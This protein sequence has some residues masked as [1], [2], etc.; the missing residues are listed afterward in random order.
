MFVLPVAPELP[1]QTALQPA[2]T[3]QAAT[4]APAETTF[5]CGRRATVEV[6]LARE[7]AGRSAF[8]PLDAFNQLEIAIIPAPKLDRVTIQP[9]RV[10]KTYAFSRG[11]SLRAEWMVDRAL[12]LLRVTYT[13]NASSKAPLAVKLVGSLTSN[14]IYVNKFAQHDD[15][16]CALDGRGLRFSDKVQ[17]DFT[18]VMA[19]TAGHAAGAPSV[20]GENRGSIAL[21]LDIPAGEERVCD[22]SIAAATAST[23]AKAAANAKTATSLAGSLKGAFEF[24]SPDAEL[25][26][27]MSACSYVP[28]QNVRDLP[29]GPPFG[30]EGAKNRLWP[31]VTASPDYHGIFANDCIQSMWELGLLGPELYGPSE[32]SVETMFHY[33]SLESVEW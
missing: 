6:F 13:F 21:D 24:K 32:N 27:F 19:L 30:V 1:D 15:D 10:V 11:G 2:I 25:N 14:L 29:F 7:A 31:V 23:E 16:V 28:L 12:P 17:P 33:G 26:A 18:L 22:L 3:R 4:I 5:L 20:V 9:G 8:S